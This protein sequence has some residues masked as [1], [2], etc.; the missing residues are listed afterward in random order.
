MKGAIATAAL[1]AVLLGACAQA[2]GPAGPVTV[3]MDEFSFKLSQTS[4]PAGDVTFIVKNAGTVVH[5]FAI[6][7]TDLAHDKI[8]AR[9]NEPSKV[10]EPGIAG[11]IEDIDAGATKQATFKLTPGTYVLICNEPAHYAAGMHLAY[12][13]R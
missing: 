5:E 13:V 8:P 10:Q 1:A 3:T 6:L 9:P 4:S 2:T 7:R 12:T 11:E